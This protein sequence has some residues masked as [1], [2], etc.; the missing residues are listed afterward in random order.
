MSAWMPALRAVM[1]RRILVNYRVRPEVLERWV[2]R[3]FRVKVLRGWGL[4]GVCLIRLESVRPSWLPAWLGL[5]SENAAHRVAVEWDGEDGPHDGVF[6]PRRETGSILNHLAGGRLFPGAS[7]A[8]DFQCRET[9]DRIGLEMRAGDGKASLR[10]VVEPT[11]AWPE[12]SVLGSLDE[13]SKFFRGGCRGWSPTRD[14]RGFEGTE[15]EPET[16]SMTPLKV[17]DL[18][19]AYFEDV[20]RFPPGTVEL[21]SAILMRGIAH[22]WR[23]LGRMPAARSARRPAP[24]GAHGPGALFRFP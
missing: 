3:P 2:P 1:A 10:V 18:K 22:T 5:A 24:R 11:E 16:W 14:G 13:A 23:D 8:A 21:D 15:L 9:P 12:G 4:A 7:G 20:R 19:S 6:I 17:V